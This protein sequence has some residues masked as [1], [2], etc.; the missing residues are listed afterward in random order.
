M[1]TAT[2]SPE[3]NKLRLYPGVQRLDSETYER[4]TAAGFKWAGSQQLFVAQMWTPT[5]EDLLLDLCGELGDEDTT[6]VDRAESRADRFSD[7]SDKRMQESEAARAGAK[8]IA[9]GIPF[10]QPILVGHHSE[11]RARKDAERIE[12]GYRK[13]ISLWETSTYWQ[14]RAAAAVAHAKYKERPDVRHRRIK[15]IEAD[16]RKA[17]RTV[18]ESERAL[19]QWSA[20]G[21]TLQRAKDIAAFD[22]ISA[23]FTLTEYP[24]ETATYEGPRSL[25]SALEDRI[26]AEEKARD[27]AVAHHVRLI[28]HERRW[29][30]HYENR[31]AYER[32]MLGE[33]G[34]LQ[35]DG[36]DIAPGG[37]VLVG[38]EWHKVLRVNRVGGRI[39]SVT[40]TPPK[41]VH[42]Q[43]TWNAGIEA[44]KD[45]RA[46]DP[47]APAGNK[48]PP[49]LNYPGAGFLHMTKAEW[50]STHSDYKGTRPAGA[51]GNAGRRACVRSLLNLTED[52]D[53]LEPHRIRTVVRGGGLHP[54]YLTDAK[55]TQP[56]PLASVPAPAEPAA[57]AA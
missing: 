14:Q 25:W 32:A 3:D 54:V 37:Q 50:S 8:R 57:E 40:M 52:S 42:W 17:E 26:I 47:T 43:D 49:L 45:Y 5:R 2:Y 38:G 13:S 24:R 55:V 35:A 23:R 10:G 34:G 18:A 9:D 29:I 41:D 12:N 1:L 7:Y 28:A 16:K 11:R 21:L 36:F 44:V 46:P 31:I 20:E 6:L 15:K 51:H 4:V 48:A 56:K 30:A 33:Q 22:H 39:N 19:K 53:Q 27:I